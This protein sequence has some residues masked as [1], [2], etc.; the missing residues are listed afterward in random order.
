MCEQVRIVLRNGLF[1]FTGSFVRKKVSQ[2][3]VRFP[4]RREVI[5]WRWRHAPFRS[6]ILIRG[7]RA[8]S[9]L[10]HEAAQVHAGLL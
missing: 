10:P 1:A 3:V 8:L 6:R 9:N 4:I 5:D 7:T 2:S